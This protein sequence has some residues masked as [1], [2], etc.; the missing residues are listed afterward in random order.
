[1]N[2]Q[3]LTSIL[4]LI[5][6]QLGVLNIKPKDRLVE[7]LGAESADVANIIAAIEEKFQ[8]TIRES[9]IAKLSTPKDIN[10]LVQSK[11]NEF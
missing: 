3:T 5:E 9:E 7:D 1:M 2:E 11:L 4:I 8:I 10:T 6:S